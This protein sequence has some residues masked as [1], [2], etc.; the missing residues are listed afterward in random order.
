MK[1]NASN[2]SL[3]ISAGRIDQFP[4]DPIPQIAFSGRSNVGKSSLINR[5][6]GRNSLARTSSTPG[7][8]ITVNF[9]DIDRKLFFVDLPG[10]GYARRSD[11][12]RKVWSSL[13][14]GYFTR[15]PNLD[16]LRLVVQLID[17]RVGPTEDDR[18]MI[19]WLMTS[20]IPFILVGTK[21]DKLN[22]T[23]FSAF[24]KS[25]TEYSATVTDRSPVFFSSVT[26]DGKQQLWSVINLLTGITT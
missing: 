17:S 8:T 10:Y 21:T 9:Y 26:G 11:E 18:M 3:R 24:Q 6:L 12:S 1:I 5:M 7:K 14:D 25:L 13:T 20:G 2:S 4:R 23:G 16:L 15:N 19:D 22:K